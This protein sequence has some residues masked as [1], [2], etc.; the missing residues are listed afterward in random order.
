MWIFR[1]VVKSIWNFLLLIPKIWPLTP[2]KEVIVFCVW[3]SFKCQQQV[4]MACCGE[5]LLL[6]HKQ[7][8][9]QIQSFWGITELFSIYTFRF[10]QRSMQQCLFGYSDVN[11]YF[12]L[13]TLTNIWSSGECYMVILP[14]V[15]GCLP[16]FWQGAKLND[17][18]LT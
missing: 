2:H 4:A 6:S 5:S 15:D 12:R 14:E 16:F 1:L 13:L 7:T 9:T 11:V 10:L 3:I 8:H 17:L 18:N